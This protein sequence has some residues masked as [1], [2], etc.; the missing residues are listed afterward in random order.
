MA[1]C[2]GKARVQF[3]RSL[4]AHFAERSTASAWVGKSA[5]KLL[6]AMIVCQVLALVSAIVIVRWPESFVNATGI[7][8]NLAM[9]FLAWLQMKKHQELAQ[10]YGLAAQG[11][12]F[13]YEQS[14]QVRTEEELSTYV[15]NSENAIS[16]EHKMWLGRRA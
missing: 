11:L 3:Y 4:S 6:G 15:M 9:A 10:S 5:R 7:F 16:R 12:S 14:S 1:V 2:N 13:A 8:V